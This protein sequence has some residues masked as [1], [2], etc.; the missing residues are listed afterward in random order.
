MS[1]PSWSVCSTGGHRWST[2]KQYMGQLQLWPHR[3]G[4]RGM[5]GTGQGV[6]R[7]TFNEVVRGGLRKGELKQEGEHWEGTTQVKS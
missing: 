3:A 6:K 5:N 2:C 7:A 1:S 4:Q